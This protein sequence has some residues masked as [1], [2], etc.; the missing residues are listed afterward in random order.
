MTIVL[1]ALALAFSLGSLFDPTET[2]E[3]RIARTGVIR[4]GYAVEAPFAFQDE[5]GRVTGEAPELARAIWQRLGVQRI[6][7]VQTDFASLIPQLRAGRFDQIAGGLF[8]RPD[9]ERLV[10]FTSPSVCLQP[11]LLVRQD[12]PLH[13]HGFTDIAQHDGVRLAV[14]TGAVEGGDAVRA[15]V[16]ADRIIAYPN[17]DLA[18][19]AMRL[20]LADALSLSGPTVQRLADTHPDMQRALPFDSAF[21]RPGCGAF[22][23]RKTDQK[24]CRQF[25]QTLEIFMGSEEHLRLL[26]PF[27]LGPDELPPADHKQHYKQLQKQH[28]KEEQ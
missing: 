22:A 2:T 4:I 17:P 18:I 5:Q 27:E 19:R 7:W 16:P 13:L 25:N 14:I 6:E 23:F 15:W 28:Q 9:R 21:V 3:D 11:A 24:L 8:I 1:L 20:G 26:Q 12:N 10:A